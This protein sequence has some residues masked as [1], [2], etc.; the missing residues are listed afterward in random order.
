MSW[1]KPL[2]ISG[3]TA[4]LILGSTV[5]VASNLYGGFNRVNNGPYQDYFYYQLNQGS[6]DA[7]TWNRQQNVN[8][9][10]INTSLITSHDPSE[11][12]VMD[13]TYSETW[14]GL[15]ECNIIAG[16]FNGQDSCQHWHIR[17]N[18]NKP[19]TQTSKRSIACEEAGHSLGLEHDDRGSCIKDGELTITSFSGH[20]IT[21]INNFYPP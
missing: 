13:D 16:G 3:A 18:L 10:D 4:I 2:L 5:A 12:A 17:Y 6:A 7:T 1:R 19:F 14:W 20:D 11:V 8:P 15:A 9:T 21:E